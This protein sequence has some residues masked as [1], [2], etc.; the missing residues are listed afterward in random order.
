MTSVNIKVC[1]YTN[2]DHIKGI[3]DLINACIRDKMG[4][5]EPLSATDQ[6]ELTDG[7][8]RHPASVVRIVIIAAD[9][10]VKFP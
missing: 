10:L 6:I 7:L 4:G 9:V 2:P 8:G 3:A 5:G 1:D